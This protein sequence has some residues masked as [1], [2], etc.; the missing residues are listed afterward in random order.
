[1]KEK[2][3]KTNKKF[4]IEY[5]A[6]IHTESPK[7]LHEKK[8]NRPSKMMEWIQWMFF[9]NSNKLSFSF[10]RLE[11]LEE[12]LSKLISISGELQFWIIMRIE[13]IVFIIQIGPLLKK[14]SFSII[15]DGA[16]KWFIWGPIT[17]TDTS[18][19]LN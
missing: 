10:R 2:N 17:C 5:S 12:R 13:L 9:L 4:R 18:L 1:M 7:N 15:P 6:K 11:D 19:T 3:K 16:F 14:K 8:T